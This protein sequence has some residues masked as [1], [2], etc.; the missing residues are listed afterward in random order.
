MSYFF[1]TFQLLCPTFRLRR[2]EV[3]SNH[4]IEM[5][6]VLGWRQIISPKCRSCQST[7][8]IYLLEC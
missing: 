6:N 3:L 2:V 5:P 7:E 1:F 4:I 8:N